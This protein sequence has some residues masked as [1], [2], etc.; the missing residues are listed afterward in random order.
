MQPGNHGITAGGACMIM[1]CMRAFLLLGV[2]LALC[3]CG[4]GKSLEGQWSGEQIGA[5]VD[6]LLAQDGSY[7]CTIAGADPLQGTY[8]QT[9]D[10]L[11]LRN[12]EDTLAYNYKWMADDKISMHAIRGVR[13]NVSTALIILARTGPAPGSVSLSSG[14]GGP[15]PGNDSALC[16]DRLSHVEKALSQYSMDFDEVFPPAQGWDYKLKPYVKD[17]V[18]FTCPALQKQS[19]EGGYAMN[20]DL[21]A[22]LVQ[23]FRD[24]KGTVSFYES[25]DEFLGAAGT[26]D[27]SALKKARH[28]NAVNFAFMDGHVKSGR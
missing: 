22:Q 17:A 4:K 24:P 21:S 20:L 26:P 10:R 15:A 25:A 6:L 11:R 16:L 13:K 27:I 2:I 1:Y 7:L 28:G 3:G 8:E 5:K 23:A 18:V 9:P 19:K 14:V 12:G